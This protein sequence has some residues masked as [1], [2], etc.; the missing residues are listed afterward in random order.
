MTGFVQLR[1]FV[2]GAGAVCLGVALIVLLTFFAN[3]NRNASD[4]IQ[5]DGIVAFSG[6][7]RR[8]AVALSLLA[9]QR[10]PRLLLVGLDNGDVV[11][12]LRHKRPDLF[13]CCV[14]VDA[15]S[16]TTREDARLAASWMR[17]HNLRSI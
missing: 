12:T 4:Q 2:Q 7:P 14:D 10:A 1:G 3:V 15:R 8:F 11:A 5:T 9:D 6:E 17:D 16:R 13:A